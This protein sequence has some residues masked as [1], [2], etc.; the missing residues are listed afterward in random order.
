MA[1]TTSLDHT[2]PAT[3]RLSQ[4]RA[5]SVAGATLA[6]AAVW[7]LAV[8]LLGTHLLV[9]FGSGASQN[10]GSTSSSARVWWRH[11]SAGRCSPC[12]KGA[13]HAPARSGPAPPSRSCSCR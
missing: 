11:R 13:P 7:V 4:T 8:P 12:S 3:T 6:A 10:V 1:T 5:L 2:K 9:R